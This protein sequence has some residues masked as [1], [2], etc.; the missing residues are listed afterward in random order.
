MWTDIF[1]KNI[2]KN[3]THGRNALRRSSMNSALGLS[4]LPLGVPDA[5]CHI[6]NTTDQ[7]TRLSNFK[8][9]IVLFFIYSYTQ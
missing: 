9:Q 3:P 7:Y 1:F 8:L 2:L 5:I 6:Q 4:L